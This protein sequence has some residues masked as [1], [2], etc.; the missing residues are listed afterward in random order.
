MVVHFVIMKILLIYVLIQDKYGLR[1]KM[2]VG[3]ADL[4]DVLIRE[5]GSGAIDTNSNEIKVN[6]NIKI[7]VNQVKEVMVVVVVMMVVW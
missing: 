5:N 1:K 6:E 7:N 2:F 4:L 3:Y